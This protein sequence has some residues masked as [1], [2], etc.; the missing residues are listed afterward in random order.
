M[1]ALR[2][3]LRAPITIEVVNPH[4]NKLG[5]QYLV[6]ESY[7]IPQEAG[8]ISYQRYTINCISD[9]PTELRISN[10]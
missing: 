4:L 5:V 3:V 10:A 9:F 7:D 1:L 6:I 2:E 8:G